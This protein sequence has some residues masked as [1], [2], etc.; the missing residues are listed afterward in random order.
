MTMAETAKK[1]VKSMESEAPKR[2]LHLTILIGHP[3]EQLQHPPVP[4]PIPILAPDPLV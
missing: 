1:N 4:I 2:N 3:D